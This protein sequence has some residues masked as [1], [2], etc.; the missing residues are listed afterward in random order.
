MFFS[1]NRKEPDKEMLVIINPCAGH[2]QGMRFLRLIKKQLEA[3]GYNVEVYKTKR[4][5]D[6][7]DYVSR[8]CIWFDA[9]TA[10]GGDGT[11]NEVIAGLMKVNYQIPIGYIPAGSTNDL[12]SSLGLSFIPTQAAADITNG[13][14]QMM[15]IGEFNGRPYTYVASC[16]IFTHASYT[17]PQ[18]AKNVFGSLAYFFEG[19]KDL[20]SVHPIHLKVETKDGVY[21]DD[22]IFAAICNSTSCGGILKLDPHKV[23]LNDGLLELL[24]IHMP[25]DVLELGQIAFALTS[26]KYEECPYL[27]FHSVSEVEITAPADEPWTLDGE[28]EEGAEHIVVRNHH[29]AYR[30]L[31]RKKVGHEVRKY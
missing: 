17:A 29:D 8:N 21:E 6:A 26:R 25:K 11:L 19:I 2:K 15:D 1:K 12:A 22:Y 4:R 20:K 30:L 7:I 14:I 23:D 27:E 24:L 9:V 31:H 13:M 5:G 16:G 3:G 10:I 28:Y 18:D